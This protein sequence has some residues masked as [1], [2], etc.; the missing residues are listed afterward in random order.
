MSDVKGIFISIGNTPNTEILKDFV[1][2]TQQGYVNTTD[3]I[4][5]SQEGVY[6]AGDVTDTTYRQAI[7]AAGFGCIAALEVERYL[8]QKDSA[9]NE[10]NITQTAH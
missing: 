5:T 6:A 3:I 10:K 4:K 2:L 7:S 8:A 1:K 9:R